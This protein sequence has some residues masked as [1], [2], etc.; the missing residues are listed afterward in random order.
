MYFQ[1]IL[2][3][4]ILGMM[5][6]VATAQQGV[7]IYEKACHTCH[8]VGV[9]GAPKKG[10]RISWRKRLEKKSMPVLIEH[11][12]KGFKAMPPQGRCFDCSAQDIQAAIE[13][14]MQDGKLFKKANQA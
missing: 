10:D 14:M 9:N 11:V 8:A 13:W 1:L 2:Y 5:S 6:C 7:E 3:S 12:Q 4:I